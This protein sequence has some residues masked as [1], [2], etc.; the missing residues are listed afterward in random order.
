M[1]Q[2]TT[3]TPLSDKSN[4]IHQKRWAIV[5]LSSIPLIMT[6]GNSMLIP[7]LPMM[8]DKLDIS[9]VQSSY[10]ITFYSIVA[11]ILIPVA[12]FL[13]DRYGRKMVI[14][15]SL[16]IT[17]AGGALSAYAAWQMKNPYPFILIGR[18]LQGVGTAGAAPIV[19]PLVGD[20][21]HRDRDVSATL[22]IIE[23]ANT[24]GKV[25]SPILGSLL[26]GF[27]WFLPFATIPIFC[28]ISILS[29]L[30]LV[31]RPANEKQGPNVKEFL[32]N[33]R[34]V[35]RIHW[36]W[37]AAVFAIGAIVMFILF[38][39]LFYLSSNLEEQFHYH[40][41]KKGFVLAVP[42]AALCLS[43]FIT[44]KI[45]KENMV[46]MKWIIFSSVLVIG[47]SVLSIAFSN[48]FFYLMGVFLVC[49]IGIG[50]SLPALDALINQSIQKEIR[51]TISSIYSSMR[52]IGVAAGPLFMAY[53]MKGQVVFSLL[54]MSVFCLVAA[55]L[56]FAA[57]KPDRARS[58]A[59]SP[60]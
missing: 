36:R 23:T 20:M 12:G 34:E 29:V 54:I 48:S 52:Y 33:T 60:T 28:L 46:L 35:F 51:G 32:H 21:F 9:K 50:A 24:F 59:P 22:G 18:T 4:E 47:T 41:V 1:E 57:V 43:S 7:V 5:A 45:I 55:G 26:A 6:L 13:S 37:L 8:E 25:L 30:F 39:V 49:G 17:A 15:P 2:I 42:L 31:K 53:F 44:G 14:I 58:Q 10:I 27:I 3:H 38:A 40:G 11:I 56:T 16:M 19:L